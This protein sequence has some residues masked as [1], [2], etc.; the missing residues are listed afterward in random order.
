MFTVGKQNKVNLEACLSTGYG[1]FFYSSDS[2]NTKS[3]AIGSTGNGWQPRS[4]ANEFIGVE[5]P[6]K[7]TFYAVDV[8][9][10]ANNRMNSFTV[11]YVD[12]ASSKTFKRLNSY[13][14][15]CEAPGVVKTIYFT[16]VEA[17]AIRIRARIGLPNIKIE[18]Y[19]VNQNY[20]PVENLKNDTIIQKTI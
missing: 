2:E 11:E 14:L 7:E 9:C 4:P 15:V 6:N 1:R 3:V 10:M 20:K 17:F 16:P 8:Q 13:D 18:F 5:V 12:I 19:Y